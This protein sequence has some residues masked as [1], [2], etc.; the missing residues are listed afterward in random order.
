VVVRALALALPAGRDRAAADEPAQ[1]G[2]DFIFICGTLE[3]LAALRVPLDFCPTQQFP[4]SA[5]R[6][7]GGGG[8]LYVIGIALPIF[9]YGV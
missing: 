1:G 7:A 6:Q 8:Y 2:G 3:V 5:A 4:G 9:G